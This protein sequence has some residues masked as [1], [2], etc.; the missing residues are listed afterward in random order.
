MKAYLV[1]P[2][3]ALGLKLGYSRPLD[4]HDFPHGSIPNRA[5]MFVPG[6][7]ELRRHANLGVVVPGA[8]TSVDTFSFHA[9]QQHPLGTLAVD[10]IGRVYRYACI[11]GVTA[12]VGKLYQQAAPIPDH[13]AL[14]AVAEA[15]GA[16]SAAD[17]ITVTPGATAGAANLYSEGLLSISDGTGAG[18]AYRVSGHKAITASVAF[19]LYLDPDDRI[20]VALDSTSRYGLTHS[21]YQNI[22]LVPTARTGVICGVAVSPATNGYYGW[23]QSR[24]PCAVLINGTPAVTSPVANSATT[25]GA[26]DVW[27]TAAAAVTITPVG[28]MMQVGVSTK[29]NVVFL[30][31]D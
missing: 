26:V 10:K 30:N 16:G 11:G 22:I 3:A 31:I 19:N 2:L 4:R 13:L 29:F 1:D 23:V 28:H 5:G 7:G 20:A 24:G 14:T 8:A 9:A 17:P 12:A 25:T 27:T 21:V 15:I 18:L 6:T